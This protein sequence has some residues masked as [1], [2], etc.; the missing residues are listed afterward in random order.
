[1]G[2][3]RDA[4]ATEGTWFDDVAAA[5]A[6]RPELAARLRQ[7]HLESRDDAAD[8]LLEVPQAH[9]VRTRSMRALRLRVRGEHRWRLRKRPQI[10]ATRDIDAEAVVRA[11]EAHASRDRRGSPPCQRRDDFRPWTPTRER[12]LRSPVSMPHLRTVRLGA[13]HRVRLR[14][15]FRPDVRR[16]V[17]VSGMRVPRS[18]GC[19]YMPGL[20]PRLRPI[21][22]SQ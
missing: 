17:L 9:A 6:S 5:R 8:P 4:P 21:G 12:A 18:V 14:R 10:A 16:Y 13:V 7:S 22:R 3:H 19:R 15:A 2:E 11:A 20:R 1:M